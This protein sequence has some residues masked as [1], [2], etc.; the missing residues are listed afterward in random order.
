VG[1]R[2]GMD[3]VEK[4]KIYSCRELNHGRPVVAHH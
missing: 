1:Y 4:R 3:V 2:V